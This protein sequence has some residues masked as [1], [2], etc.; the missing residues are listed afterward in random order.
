MVESGIY[1]I[2]TNSS[3]EIISFINMLENDKNKLDINQLAQHEFIK[4]NAKYFHLIELNLQ[5]LSNKLDK[6]RNIWPIFIEDD[7]KKCL[8][9]GGNLGYFSSP[10]NKS[11]PIL[12]LP[13]QG[14]QG[15][16]IYPNNAIPKVSYQSSGQSKII[17]TSYNFSANIFQK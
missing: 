6:I 2:P 14:S 8:N 3:A 5:K 1:N 9:I 15:N 4:G 11:A 17:E 13:I 16:Q 10:I 7:E 12:S